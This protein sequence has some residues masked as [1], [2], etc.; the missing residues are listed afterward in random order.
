M[1]IIKVCELFCDG[2]FHLFYSGCEAKV[3]S[4]KRNLITVLVKNT[5]KRRQGKKVSVLDVEGN[6]RG[7]FKGKPTQSGKN[8]K[9]DPFGAPPGVIW[10]GVLQVEGKVWSTTL[11]LGDITTLSNI[12]ILIWKR[13]RYRMD[14]VLIEISIYRDISRYIAISIKYRNVFASLD[15][16]HPMGLE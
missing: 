5:M 15:I 13:F 14:L 10:S 2:R 8:W 11:S 9:A 6:P 7:L 3:L 1:W 12:A 16:L 4:K